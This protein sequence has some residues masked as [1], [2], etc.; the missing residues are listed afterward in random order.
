MQLSEMT[1]NILE[2]LK[3][4]RHSFSIK[5]IKKVVNRFFICKWNNI[6]YIQGE[7]LVLIEGSAFLL[8]LTT[9]Y[10]LTSFSVK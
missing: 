2:F 3:V 7:M 1:Q 4:G 6:C 10:M 5:K 9:T 8:D